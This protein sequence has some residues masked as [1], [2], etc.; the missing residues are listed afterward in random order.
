MLG[1]FD[2]KN[3]NYTSHVMIGKNWLREQLSA[4]GVLH[5]TSGGNTANK[6]IDWSIEKSHSNDAV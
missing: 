6:R 4:L 3:L 5:L 1:S 2:N